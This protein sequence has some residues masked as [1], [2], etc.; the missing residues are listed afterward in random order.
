MSRTKLAFFLRHNNDIDHMIP[1]AYALAQSGRHELHLVVCTHPAYL[2]DARLKLLEPFDNVRFHHIMDFAPLPAEER[3]RI[4]AETL[5]QRPA[6]EVNFGEIWR[7]WCGTQMFASLFGA[8]FGQDRRGAVVFDWTTEPLAQAIVKLAAGLGIQSVSLPHGVKVF[9]N[10]L[11][12]KDNLNFAEL[13]QS[14]CEFSIFDHV[15]LPNRYWHDFYAKCQVATN[16][17]IL[18]SPRYCEQWRDILARLT[19]PF[20]KDVGQALRVVFFLRD[21]GYDIFWEEV[22][23]SYRLILQF[24]GVHLLV[25]HHRRSCAQA[26]LRA[27]HP[28]LFETSHP[29]LT[30]LTDNTSSS[31][32]IDWAD[33]VVDGGTSMS[34]EAVLKGKPLLSLEY[35]HPN[36][37]ILVDYL[38]SCEMRT[39]DDFYF[40]MEAFVRD[41][42]KAFYDPDEVRVFRD[43]VIDYFEP[44]VLGRYVNFFDSILVR[45]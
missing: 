16:L 20:P 34:Y 13:T 37:T 35:L 28:A 18:G 29:N 25:R 4:I 36:R 12:T 41:K 38:K 44:D 32:L 19:K 24:P 42:H 10:W 15:V 31:A 33:V 17:H 26:S 22:V 9:A 8:I 23:R 40:Q 5:G 3:T 30:I 6:D 43:N 7:P 45:V 14:T 39:R 2:D 1:V 11:V 27:E 21:Q